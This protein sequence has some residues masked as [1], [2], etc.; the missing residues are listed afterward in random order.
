MG[1][2]LQDI[3]DNTLN[4]SANFTEEGFIYEL[5]EAYGISK[6]NITKMRQSKEPFMLN[7]KVHFKVANGSGVTA[8][9]E[10]LKACPKTK[11]KKSRFLIATDFTRLLAV[12]T[13]VDEVLD[14]ALEDFFEEYGFFLPWTGREKVQVYE[15]VEADQ[16]AAAK[17]AKLFDIIRIDNPSKEPEAIDALNHF[18]TRLIFCYYA[19]DTGIFEKDVFTHHLEVH[20]D[21]DGSNTSSEL[22]HIFKVLNTANNKNYTAPLQKFPYVNGGLFEHDY[23]VPV[24][25]ARARRMLIEC[26]KIDW[27]RINPDIFGSMFQGVMDEE[28]RHELGAHYTSIPNIMKVINPLFMDDLREEFEK[29]KGSEKKLK[30]LQQRISKIK[31][32]DPACGS[33][34]FLIIAY[35]ELRHLEMDIIDGIGKISGP[36]LGCLSFMTVDHFYGIEINAFAVELAKLS[37]WLA[38]HQMNVEFQ[39]KF[40]VTVPSI[41]LKDSARIVAANACRID[42]E[43]VCPKAE[44]DE[45]YILG[46][47]PYLGFSIQNSAQKN[48]LKNTFPKNDYKRLDYISC[49]FKLAS[50]YI[51]GIRASFSFV[52]TNSICQ[53]EQVSLLWPLLLADGQ[54]EISFAWQSFKWTN[55]AQY[56]A[57]VICIIIGVRN[58]SDRPKYLIND[59]LIRQ[60]KNINPYL[61]EYK[62]NIV[63]PKRLTPLSNIASMQRGDMPI[64][65]GN[66]IISTEKEKNDLL[67]TYPQLKPYIRKF[68]GAVE[69]MNNT[70][71]W[72]LWFNRNDYDLAMSI[73]PIKERLES[74]ISMRKDSTNSS[75]N[76]LAKH[77]HLFGQI[78]HKDVNSIII[79]S[80]TSERREYIPMGFV[81]KQTIISN[82]AYS[83]P[84]ESAYVFGILSTKIHMV[85]LRTTCGRLKS[86]YRYT[87]NL[88]YNTFPIPNLKESKENIEELAYNIIEARDMHPGKTLAELYDPD[89]MPQNLRDA[90]HELD[91]AVDA[92]YRKEPFKNDEERLVHLF[93]LYEKMTSGE[94]K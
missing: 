81:E 61:I 62:S 6:A 24:F 83:V 64:D 85:W 26:G 57:A 11:K 28:V 60:V 45:I 41:P 35:K 5:L 18:F 89:K 39:D 56:K 10:E 90:H 55:N 21:Y 73:P 9:L 32:F 22:R 94:N 12:D 42:W 77:P 84:S 16:K 3:V 34:N 78:R 65:G 54:L 71:R 50:N 8:A 88:C 25:S 91:L 80:T 29:C 7:N 37:I 20:T 93:K 17:M 40:S 53:G 44:N 4:F 74:V 36:Q 67:E 49:W 58:R 63:I 79:P 48:D 14:I 33:G 92:I 72:C 13:K 2:Y 27:K 19:E 75:T 51:E 76:E 68:I 70:C 38:E 66:L 30:E 1:L 31:I 15:E 86:D 59:H 87:A 43:E 82:L 46:N 23:E 69:H 52:S 47:P